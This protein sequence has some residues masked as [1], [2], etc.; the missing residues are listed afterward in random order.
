MSNL[1]Q[2]PETS[3]AYA[4]M[5]VAPISPGATLA[6]AR[7]AYGLTIEQVASQLNLAPRQVVALETD[8]FTA[9]PGMVIARGF[10]R[11]YAKLLRLDP[12]P[13]LDVLG[14][15][16]QASSSVLMR[17]AISASFSESRM[18]SL[19]SRGTRNR[20]VPVAA[21]FAVLLAAGVSFGLGW[22][23][24]QILL[25]IG[26]IRAGLGRESAP[27]AGSSAAVPEGNGP[28]DG[29]GAGVVVTGTGVDSAAPRTGDSSAWPT[30]A[31][32]PP[33]TSVLDAGGIL[34]STLGQPRSGNSQAPAPSSTPTALPVPVTAM[35]ASLSH[36]ASPGDSKPP[37]LPNPN[38]LVLNFGQDSWIELRQADKTALVA[39]VI[40]AGSVETF[41]LVGPATL[42]VGNI[43]GVKASLRG[44]PL[45]L[46]KTATGNVAKLRL[47]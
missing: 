10:L 6:A 11:A 28:V 34:S 31:D 1:P 14:D 19:H 47:K 29:S 15:P 8:N 38:A 46:G 24:E 21:G 25:K 36:L 27:G 5:S 23:P 41:E 35:S 17:H 20:L 39:K 2:K 12:Q 40:K 44:V 30:R 26:Q 33:G 32:T 9:L 45:D 4:S 3:T 16:Y 7:E 13:L 22:W 18:P 43:A 42:T 37:A